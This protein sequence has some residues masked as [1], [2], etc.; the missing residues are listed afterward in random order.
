[1]RKDITKKLLMRE[2][3]YLGRML[4]F[5]II[6]F[7]CR[8]GLIR[9]YDTIDF[10]NVLGIKK[11]NINTTN[12]IAS[13]FK[14]EK[15]LQTKEGVIV[16]FNM[17][18]CDLQAF[19]DI[20]TPMPKYPFW[21]GETEVSSWLYRS[22]TNQPLGWGIDEEKKFYPMNLISLNGA[23]DFC[24]KLSELEGFDPYYE[25]QGNATKILGGNGYRLPYQIEWEYAARAGTKNK[26]A[27]TNDASLIGYYAWYKDNHKDQWA[28]TDPIATKKPNEWG[29]Y[30][31]SGNVE[32]WCHVD[33]DKIGHIIQTNGILKGG[34][35]ESSIDALAI[36]KTNSGGRKD[37]A[38]AWIGFRI[39]RNV[40]F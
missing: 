36:S 18:Y 37:Y 25:I 40:L 6:E 31:M 8:D 22:I 3:R 13:G 28:P 33:Q 29:I 21:I 35:Y 39:V 30:D 9:S 17:V 24:N 14:E 15:T 32:E 2:K 23:I 27:G 10:S 26:W 5:D 16:E 38:T 19:D 1:M 12:R 20:D 34:N 11:T 4:S 7:L